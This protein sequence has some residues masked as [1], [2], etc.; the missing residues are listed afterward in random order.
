MRRTV[1]CCDQFTIMSSPLV[2]LLCRA[3]SFFVRFEDQLFFRLTTG[4]TRKP[5]IFII[6]RNGIIFIN[7]I[8]IM[9][10]L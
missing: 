3:N 5:V 6:H 9:G 7:L 1:P 10:V 8:I 4:L 2:L